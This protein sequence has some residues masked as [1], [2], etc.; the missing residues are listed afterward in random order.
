MGWGLYVNN[1]YVNR[2]TK[3]AL[4]DELKEHEDF[5]RYLASRLLFLAGR[6]V[7]D[8]WIIEHVRKACREVCDIFQ[9]VRSYDEYDP[10]RETA[11]ALDDLRD[12]TERCLLLRLAQNAD[13]ED[14]TED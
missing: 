4:R 12:A 3:A 7:R 10:H 6:S 14:V 2:V 11:D 8:G 9:G 5:I 13:D 1:V